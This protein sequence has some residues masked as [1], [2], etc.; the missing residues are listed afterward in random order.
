VEAV[1]EI[2]DQGDHNYQ[3]DKNNVRI[4]LGHGLG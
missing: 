2:K 4:D 3:E 1:G